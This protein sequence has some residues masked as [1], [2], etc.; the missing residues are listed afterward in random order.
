MIIDK[1]IDGKVTD[2]E[3]IDSEVKKLIKSNPKKYKLKKKFL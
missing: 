2:L 1:V 3:V